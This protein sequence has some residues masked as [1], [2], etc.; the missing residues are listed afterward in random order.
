MPTLVSSV[1]CVLVVRD[2]VPVEVVLPRLA[3]TLAPLAVDFDFVLVVPGD[4]PARTALAVKALVEVTP[5]T[6]AAFLSE[7]ADHD[8][9]RLM[10][11]DHAVGDHVL[12]V[13]PT[14]AD[15]DAVPALLEGLAGGYDVVAGDTRAWFVVRRSLVSTLLLRA[16]LALYRHATGVEVGRSRG[17]P[18]VLTRA[19]A[20]FVASRPD[21]EI[22][23]RARTIGAGF[24]T[25][26]IPLP[27]IEPVVSRADPLYRVWPKALRLLLAVSGLPLRGASYLA[28]AGGLLSVLYSA[29]V[30]AVYLLK[31][32]VEAGWTTL[33]LQ[34]AGMMF[35]FS[36]VLMFLSEYVIQIHAANPPRGRR[37]LV[38]R[39]V[40]SP[41]SRRSMRLN[42]VDA[43]GEFHVGAPAGVARTTPAGAG[44]GTGGTA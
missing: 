43:L 10:G 31:P 11:I 28:A 12:F 25:R 38:L 29:Y 26:V 4:V 1:S 39:E 44:R 34:L 14:V 33:S 18:R 41:L 40:R 13:D 30:V 6:T 8:A 19:A 36:V 42:V 27:A 3:R 23:L 32:H 21:G 17:G 15:V 37:S 16:Y 2:G 9:A 22:L 35:I 7:P 24:P 20:L 5:D